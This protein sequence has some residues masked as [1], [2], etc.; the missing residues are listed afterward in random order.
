MAER[1]VARGAAALRRSRSCRRRS[2]PSIPTPATSSRWS[3]AGTSAHRS[4]TAPA[5]A[6]VSRGRRSSRC[7]TRRRSST[8]SRQCPMLAGS[9]CTSP[10]QGPDEWS[11]RNAD[12]E[13]AGHADAA[14]RA[15]RV[16]QPCGDDA[17]AAGRLASGPAARLG[18]RAAR[19][20]RRAVAVARHRPGHA[21]R[22]DRRVRDV[23]QRRLRGRS[24]AASSGSST[25][26]AA[27][28]STN[29]VAARARDLPG[30][31]VPDGLDAAGRRRSR[32]PASAAARLGVRFAVGGKTGTTN[33]FKDAWF[34][35][36]SSSI[37][38]GRLGGVRSAGDHRPRRRTGRAT[39]C[40]S[41]ATSCAGLRASACPQD[42]RA[43]DRLHEE[44]AV[45]RLVPEAGRQAARST[46]NTSRRATR[47]RRSLCPIHKGTIK[48]QVARVMQ[49]FLSG[50]GKRIRGIFR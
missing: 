8:A 30:D 2:S 17:A 37:V 9:R 42:V 28:R 6:A 19:H 14:R 36:F 7:S 38:V 4:S 13:S 1:A 31:G 25:P 44:H 47:C 27:W 49:G 33:E 43:P 5:A 11:P 23:P 21:A 24:R 46:P 34:V 48:Q 41:G 32:A 26:T 29:P 12:G 20:A 15:D 3:A 18:R 22:A 10:P 50:L 39:R 45:P 35:G 40:P 16:G